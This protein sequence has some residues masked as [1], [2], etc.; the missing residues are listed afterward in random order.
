MR[1]A[2]PWIVETV[3]CTP[4]GT[5][6]RYVLSGLSRSPGGTEKEVTVAYKAQD[7]DVLRMYV[8]VITH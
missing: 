8:C 7:V 5:T 6:R 1:G 2:E 3:L 4:R